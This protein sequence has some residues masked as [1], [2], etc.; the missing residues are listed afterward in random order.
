[1]PALRDSHEGE[2]GC[3]L[4]CKQYCPPCLDQPAGSGRG[5]RAGRKALVPSSKLGFEVCH[6]EKGENESSSKSQ[7]LEHKAPGRSG[8]RGAGCAW[9]TERPAGVGRWA[10]SQTQRAL[11]EALGNLAFPPNIW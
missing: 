6:T 11:C 2:T 5:F 9:G 1:M 7:D 4:V 10:A 3:R 8:D